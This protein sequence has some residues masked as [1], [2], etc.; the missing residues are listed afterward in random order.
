ML[1]L[2]LLM[3]TI[4][5]LK[6]KLLEDD[7]PAYQIAAKLGI[8]PSTLSAYALGKQVILPRHLRKLARYFKVPQAEILG[9]SEYALEAPDAPV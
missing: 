6:V 5:N 3:T 8:H 7:L 2:R 1:V 4:S 9:T